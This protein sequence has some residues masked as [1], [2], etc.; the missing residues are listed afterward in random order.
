MLIAVAAGARLV[1]AP[2]TPAR[3][4]PR[5]GLVSSVGSP[6]PAA[7]QAPG[8]WVRSPPR[9]RG[10]TCVRWLRHYYTS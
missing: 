4:A 10:T 3:E 8:T 9:S 1:L 2:A 5:A 7:G 6:V